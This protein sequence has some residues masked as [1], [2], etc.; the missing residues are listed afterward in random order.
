M[1]H[2]AAASGPGEPPVSVL[3]PGAVAAPAAAIA[4]SPDAGPARPLA[5]PRV[6][7]AA[8]GARLALGAIVLLTLAVVAEATAGPSVLVPRSALAFPNWESGPLHDVT[9]RLITDP[10]TLGEALS[11]ALAMMLV[12]YGVVL[13]T[14]RSVSLRL[15]AAVVVLLHV[16][17]VFS[18]PM[19]LTD[20]FNYLGYARLG[21][22]HHLDPYTH[23]MS[24]ETFDPVYRLSSWHDLRS[25]Y[26]ELF[27]MLSYPLALLPL[28]V[29]YWI[30]KLVTVALSLAFVALVGWCARR[31][32]R[33]PRLAVAFV[34]LNPVFLIYEIG[35]FH[36]DFFM[37]V[38]S[39]AAIALVLAGRDR[40]AGA[41]LMTAIAVKFTAVVLGPF[42]L[43][44]LA[45]TARR[46]RFVEGGA[47]AFV[48]LLAAS[49]VCFGTAL[50][51]LQQQSSLLTGFS[52]PNLVGLIFGIGGTPF[53][54]KLAD[55]L[56][57]AVVVGHLV[58]HRRGRW[59][60]GAGW[61]TF[62][63]I[64]SL[65]WAVPWYVVWLLPLAVLG[66]SIPLRAAALA[67][68][69]FL[70]FAFLPVT[71]QY[72]ADHHINLLRT[73][74]GRASRLLQNRLAS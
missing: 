70:M 33:D 15:L 45:T 26:G 10:R 28:A 19:Q 17:L 9:V 51:N 48:P 72:L 53:M 2:S 35:G 43:V 71:S 40:F 34:A 27:T 41:S 47:I 3:A 8:V 1:R 64:L 68:T 20:V 18:P 60:E 6:R 44:A 29:A 31:L 14:V 37:L 5:G 73:P 13:L 58:R 16:I 12:A 24:A 74:A 50:P 69:V 38:P 66:R 32:G 63:L 7:L 62:A 55:L 42:L 56:V 49:L 23:G 59:L 4:T 57:V 30:L 25:P 52:V 11:A 21:A 61:S 22:L 67:V 36:N 65:A 54:L 46:R 39:M